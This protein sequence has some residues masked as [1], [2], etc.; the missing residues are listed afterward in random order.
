MKESLADA[1]FQELLRPFPQRHV[2]NVLNAVLDAATSL[3]KKTRMDKENWLTRRLHGRLLQ[4]FP[5]RDGPL[6]IAMQPEIG[7]EDIDADRPAGQLDIKVTCGKGAHVYFAIEAKRLRVSD[8]FGR[9]DTG[10]R[11]YV[12]DGMMRF[13]SGQYA[14]RM[15][16]GA[17]L[18]Y[19]FDGNTPAARSDIAKA[20]EQRRDLL[21]LHQ[22]GELRRSTILPDGPVDETVHEPG[23]RKFILYHVLVAV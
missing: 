13:V 14:L 18:G 5:F 17:M 9:V 4:R 16:S 19:V 21:M 3:K 6:D 23:K 12:K 15:N 22:K 7:H 2:R 11:E 20:I 1:S 10:A 8:P